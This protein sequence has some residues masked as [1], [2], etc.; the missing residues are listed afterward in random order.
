MPESGEERR[1][2]ELAGFCG[3]NP[4]MHVLSGKCAPDGARVAPMAGTQ[5]ARL[6]C[7]Y[8]S[9]RDGW[10]QFSHK[11]GVVV[12][13]IEPARII[14]ESSRRNRGDAMRDGRAESRRKE[15]YLTQ[16]VD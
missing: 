7:E 5:Q 4:G 16:Y 3:D 10:S 9:Q 1:G 2:G 13:E 8:G 15:A 6:S 14:H 11:D 12:A